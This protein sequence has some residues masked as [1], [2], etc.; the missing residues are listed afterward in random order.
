MKPD[1]ADYMGAQG[2]AVEKEH[3]IVDG[4]PSETQLIHHLPDL[5]I[6]FHGG[7]LQS[8]DCAKHPPDLYPPVSLFKPLGLTYVYLLFK[9]SPTKVRVALKE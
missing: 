2:A 4:T 5:L 1:D 9:Y 6:P 3:C 7:L 8:V